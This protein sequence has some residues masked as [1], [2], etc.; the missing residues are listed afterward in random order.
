MKP[1]SLM[2]LLFPRYHHFDRCK[3]CSHRRGVHV[4][5][6]VDVADVGS[7]HPPGKKV[8]LWEKRHSSLY[9]RL[10]PF[11]WTKNS[12]KSIFKVTTM[13]GGRL[14]ESQFTRSL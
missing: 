3:V 11:D 2:V 5:R 12:G 1:P 10:Q 9:I 4:D 7:K 13:R 14:S 8:M 6:V